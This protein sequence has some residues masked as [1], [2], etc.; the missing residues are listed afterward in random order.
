MKPCLAVAAV[1]CLVH[2]WVP[3]ALAGD[4]RC[5]CHGR[6]RTVTYTLADRGNGRYEASFLM[7]GRRSIVS[8]RLYTLT[9]LCQYTALPDDRVA[10]ACQTQSSSGAVFPV[11]TEFRT[12][13]P[14]GSPPQMIAQTVEGQVC[15]TNGRSIS[16][17]SRAESPF[18]IRACR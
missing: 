2:A 14:P 11:S 15:R 6:D 9:S 4:A 8:G 12:K 7:D 13:L 1:A 5:E 18:D 16:D 3:P 17:W 10:I